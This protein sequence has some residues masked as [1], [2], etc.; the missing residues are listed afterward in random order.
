MRMTKRLVC[1]RTT[2][3]LAW[4]S[5]TGA[6]AGAQTQPR[7]APIPAAPPVQIQPPQIEGQP[8]RDRVA[9]PRVGNGVL[10]G[11]VVDG[12]TGTPVARARVRLQTGPA[13]SKPPVLTDSS[14]GFAFSALPPGSYMLFVEKPTYMPSQYP[15]IGRSL[16]QRAQPL[17][18]RA[19]EVIAEITVPIFHGGAIS[20]R[21]V[22][23]HGDV[24]DNAEVRVLWLPR[25]GRPSMRGGGQ[26]NDLGE[27]RIPRLQPGRYLLRVQPRPGYSD[28]S[29]VEPLS[30]P[31]PTYYP[32]A[33]ALDQAQPI[34]VNRG[35]TIS[36]LEMML[37]EGTPTLVTGVVLSSDGQALTTGGSVNA[38][39]V[40]SEAVGGFDS[41]GTGIRPDGT[42]RLPLPPGEYMLEAR[43]MSRAA[44]N[45]PWRPENEQYGSVRVT[46]A[47]AGVEAVS[48]MVGRGATATGRLV[49][50]GT[51]PPPPSPG[52]TRGLLFSLDGGCRQG[53]TTISPDWTFKVEGL[54]G[55]CSAPPQ[56]MFGRWMLK[57]V[58]FRGDNLL[59]KTITFEQ[60]QQYSNVQIVVTDRRPEMEFH[61]SGDDGQPTREY[62]AIVFPSDKA[63]WKEIARY[64][65]TVVPL[66]M[67]SMGVNRVGATPRPNIQVSTSLEVTGGVSSGIT[68]VQR[69]TGPP[70][71]SGI[72]PGEYY[73]I[74]VDD[75]DQ[76]DS[77]DPGI[78]E[79]LTSSAVRVV[80]PDEGLVEVPL[81]RVKLSDLVR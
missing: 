56:A 45:Q 22:D 33:L 3:V 77:R 63:R 55:I 34:A 5:L 50:E 21:V 57:A 61:V 16:R 2:W 14:G 46:V 58:T 66:P 39:V 12:V 75:I 24:V 44:P 26:T 80:V 38:R 23:A 11:R 62:V 51:T 69:G 17:M 36:G 18:L 28:E 40:D 43:V 71:L 60:G 6:W 49:F 76:E 53:Q 1:R 41:G 68:T 35:E 70:R 8:P 10:K 19:G 78:L 48:I 72:A 27:F 31:L 30:Q 42:F 47:G 32:N 59:D 74:A 79:R 65:R 4:L 7:Q 25:G 13:G 81:Q 37:A 64:V 15:E 29:V 54:S 9:T 67:P 20:G 52:Q 73:V